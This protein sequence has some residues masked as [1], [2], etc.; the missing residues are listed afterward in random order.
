MNQ[1]IYQLPRG[2]QL[3]ALYHFYLK[4]GWLEFEQYQLSSEF[5]N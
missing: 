4:I 5:K 3:Q 1:G 2:G